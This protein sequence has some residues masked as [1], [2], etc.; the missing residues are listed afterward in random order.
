MNKPTISRCFK[1]LDDGFSLITV[2]EN[3][4]PNFAWKKCQ[5]KP[6]QKD[7]FEKVY[8]YSGG[9]EFINKSTGEVTE[10]K[11]SVGIGIVT[12][13]NNVEVIDIDLK[14]LATLKDQQDFWNEYTTYLRESIDDFDSKFVIY[15]T[16]NN[17]YHIIYKCATIKGNTKIAKLQGMQEAII[18]SRGTGGYVWIYDNQVSKTGYDNVQEISEKDRDLLWEISRSFNYVEQQ[19]EQPKDVI[20]E[21]RKKEADITPWED[22][23]RQTRVWDLI[24]HEFTIVKKLSD[25]LIIRRHGATSVSSGSIFLNDNKMYL[26]STGTQYPNQKP[27]S[28]FDIYAI[29]NH[30]GD[31]KKTAKDLYQ[32]NYGSRHVK[33][34]AMKKDVVLHEKTEEQL[35]SDIQFPI[36]VLTEDVKK[37]LLL[38]NKALNSNIDY[39]GCSFLWLLSLI[40]GNSIKVRVKGGWIESGVV[41]ISLVGEAGIGKTPSISRIIY[42]LE[43]INNKEIKKYIKQSKQYEAYMC[44]DKKEKQ[45]NEEVKKPSKTQIIVS[46]FTIEAITDL[47]EESKNAV[48]VFCDEL[49]GWYK[50]MNKYRAGSDLEFWLSSWSNKGIAM[51]RKT[52]K[53]SFVESPILPVLGGIQPKIL[54]QFFTEE[55]KDNGFIDRMLTTYPDAKVDEYN[56]D[57]L[58]EEIIQWYS[59]YVV[60][61]YNIIKQK[62]IQYD[63]DGE[64]KSHIIPLSDGA[65]KLWIEVFNKITSYQNSDSENEYMKSMYPKQKSY[66]PRFAL[67]LNALYSYEDDSNSIDY[68]SEKAMAG[69]IKLS[70]YF[71]LMAKKHKLNSIEFSEVKK[72]VVQNENKSTK[73]KIHEILRKDPATK[74]AYISSILG[75]SRKTVYQYI[76]E[77]KE[78]L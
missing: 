71:V 30:Y 39:M 27:L 1:L 74:V 47:H 25:K 35:P 18:E 4:V 37:Y 26:F 23:N 70:E 69:A 48:G 57:D 43:R 40:I 36:D 55:N 20:K 44:L 65:N 63:P 76:N 66:I 32:K 72:V 41:W 12:G 16:V 50:D 64:I 34:D 17:G 62:V 33:E 29:K 77:L 73:E 24:C 3:K 61:F 38:C 2:G 51:N 58:S 52:A 42:P 53:S 31:F 21:Y 56:E 14:V 75:V 10:I 7:E 13:Y 8:N 46:D 78:K 59:D 28:P 60:N 45:N 22:F 6:Y 68:I 9:K 54:V 67:L 49:A 15:K 5:T 19:P 11:P